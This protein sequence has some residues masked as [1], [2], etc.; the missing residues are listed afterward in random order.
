MRCVQTCSDSKGFYIKFFPEFRLHHHDDGNLQSYRRLG[1]NTNLNLDA[2]SCPSAYFDSRGWWP[3]PQQIDVLAIL[4]ISKQFCLRHPTTISVSPGATG[5]ASK[6]TIPGGPLLPTRATRGLS[7][8]LFGGLK[9]A[10]YELT[11]RQVNI[12]TVSFEARTGPQNIRTSVRD[13]IWTK[14][15]PK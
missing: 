9:L 15:T 6:A 11:G 10:L 3:E 2:L 8:V 5:Y 12:R 13:R 14:R 1:C 4:N 7:M